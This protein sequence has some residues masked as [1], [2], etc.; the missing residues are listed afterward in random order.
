MFR[1]IAN[2]DL[3]DSKLWLKN[4]KITINSV[5][6][7]KQ[8]TSSYVSQSPYDAKVAHQNSLDADLMLQ[9]SRIGQMSVGK[10][11]NVVKKMT[12]IEEEVLHDFVAEEGFEYTDPVSGDVKMI[13]H[14]IPVGKYP[15][16]DDT[17]TGIIPNRDDSFITDDEVLAITNEHRTIIDEIGTRLKDLKIQIS[18]APTGKARTAIRDSIQKLKDDLD[19]ENARY[20]DFLVARDEHN[21]RITIKRQMKKIN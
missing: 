10:F 15:I 9:N 12:P 11:K 18:I 16:L 21:A 14:N 13:R 5:K 3:K 19:K 4:S 17:P 7:Y 1:T 20:E 2:Q 8:P 6:N